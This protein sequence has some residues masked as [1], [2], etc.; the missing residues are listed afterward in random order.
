M[1][2]RGYLADLETGQA[3]VFGTILLKGGQIETGFGGFT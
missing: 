2:E 3:R 1:G